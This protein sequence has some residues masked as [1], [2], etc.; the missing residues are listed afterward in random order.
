MKQAFFNPDEPPKI[1]KLFISP[2]K[3]SFKNTGFLNLEGSLLAFNFKS[4]LIGYSDFLP[5]PAF[6]EPKLFNQLKAVQSGLFSKRFM[7]SK[8]NAF[9]DALARQNKKKSVFWIEVSTQ[10]LFN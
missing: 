8:H 4:D 7:I 10:S 1:S 2:Y 6:G 5:W 3:L 9:L